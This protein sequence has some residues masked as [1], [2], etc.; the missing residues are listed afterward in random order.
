MF[1]RRVWR[2]YSVAGILGI[3]P[4]ILMLINFGGRDDSLEFYNGPESTV[5]VLLLTSTLSWA[6][7]IASVWLLKPIEA[8]INQKYWNEAKSILDNMPQLKVIG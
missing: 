2:I 5:A 3:I 6:F 1:T 8:R 7:V 4:F